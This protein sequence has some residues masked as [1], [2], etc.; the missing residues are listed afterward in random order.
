MYSDEIL[1]A[2]DI[3]EMLAIE[4][5][6]VFTPTIDSGYRFWRQMKLAPALKDSVTQKEIYGTHK[7]S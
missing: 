3:V 1:L 6:S 4:K 7:L 5:G 2:R